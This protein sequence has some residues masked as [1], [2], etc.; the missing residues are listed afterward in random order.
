MAGGSRWGLAVLVLVGLV[1]LA[2]TEA[3]AQKKRVVASKPPV[4]VQPGARPSDRPSKRARTARRRRGPGRVLRLEGDVIKGRVQ[5]P[6][7]FYVLQ[8]TGVTFK[9]LKLTTKLVPK[10]LEALRKPP[11]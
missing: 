7:A 8:R 2:G 11:F 4:A 5:K 9:G 1:G 10:I 6:E 3:A